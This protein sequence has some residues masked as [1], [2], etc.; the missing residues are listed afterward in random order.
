MN[1]ARTDSDRIR[2]ELMGAADRE[3]AD[4]I[5]ARLER[6][7]AEIVARRSTPTPE[8]LTKLVSDAWE[9]MA[10][11]ASAINEASI[12]IPGDRWGVYNTFYTQVSAVEYHLRQDLANHHGV[13]VR[14]SEVI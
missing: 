8:Q 9:A 5:A 2:A 4:A 3:D 1:P 11:A 12:K 14:C 10:R 7:S 6:V 13:I